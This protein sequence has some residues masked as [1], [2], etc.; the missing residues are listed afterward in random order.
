MLREEGIEDPDPRK[1]FKEDMINLVQ[2]FDMNPN[3][4]TILMMDANKSISDKEGSLQK[5]LNSSS[6]VDTF[7]N[8]S[9]NEC[10]IPTYYRGS[11]KIDYIF[12]SLNLLPYV[13]RVGILP[14]YQ[15]NQ[16]DHRGMFIDISN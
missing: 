1:I 6:L 15:Y 3:N 16:S 8:I 14:F 7:A 11:R 10:K 13:K 4:Y 5:L 9:D 12:T 2:E